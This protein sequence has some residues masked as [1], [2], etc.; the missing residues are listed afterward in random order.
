MPK[1][2]RLANLSKARQQDAST[3]DSW[4]PR[5]LE[6]TAQS[7]IMVLLRPFF[8]PPPASQRAP[9]VRKRP[10]QRVEDMPPHTRELFQ[11]CVSC[12]GSLG[13]RTHALTHTGSTA[14]QRVWQ[15]GHSQ[16]S[17]AAMCYEARAEVERSANFEDFVDRHSSCFHSGTNIASSF[18]TTRPRHQ[19]WDREGGRQGGRVGGRW[20]EV[21]CD[22]IDMRRARERSEGER[23]YQSA[24]CRTGSGLWPWEWLSQCRR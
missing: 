23:S 11:G 8:L 20:R 4:M 10:A 1:K 17:H 18:L 7:R 16:H 15:G 5:Q 24:V 21:V 9:H 22:W 6:A 14:R 12:L 13:A 2:C 19:S 3:C